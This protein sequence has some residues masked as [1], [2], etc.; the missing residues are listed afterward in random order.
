MTGILIKRYVIEILQA[1]SFHKEL[2]C[3]LRYFCYFISG[4]LYNPT[5]VWNVV[6]DLL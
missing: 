3:F 1:V 5:K 4:V 6:T 2:K